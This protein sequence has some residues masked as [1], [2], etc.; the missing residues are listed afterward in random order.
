MK[1]IISQ[2]DPQHRFIRVIKLAILISLIELV[3]QYN[4]KNKKIIYGVIGYIGV[5]LLLSLSYDYEGFGH[6][7][8]VWSCISIITCYIIGYYLFNEPFNKY[9]KIAIILSMM[10]IYFAHKSDETG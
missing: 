8:L 6:M 3:G 4:L 10:A 9:T 2:L 1:E 5:A 7:N